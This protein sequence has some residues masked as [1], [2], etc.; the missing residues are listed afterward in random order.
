MYLE[1]FWL[2]VIGIFLSGVLTMMGIIL[3][4]DAYKKSKQ[5]RVPLTRAYDPRNPIN[6]RGMLNQQYV[7]PEDGWYEMR[8]IDYR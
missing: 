4:V 7:Q 6:A 3:A 2:S 8:P 5:P 1:H